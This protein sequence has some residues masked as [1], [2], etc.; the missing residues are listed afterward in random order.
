MSQPERHGD[1]SDSRDPA[2]DAP[3]CSHAHTQALSASVAVTGE[4]NR[5]YSRTAGCS[6]RGV[7][8]GYSGRAGGGGTPRAGF[9]K[10]EVSTMRRD[11]EH[12]QSH[13]DDDQRRRD[14][15]RQSDLCRPLPP[16]LVDALT[17]D[18]MPPEVLEKLKPEFIAPLV[19]YLASKENKETQMIFNCAAGW[20][21]R[22]AVCCAPGLCIGD[23]VRTITPEEI[24]ENWET[25]TSLDDAAPLKSVVDSFQFLTPLF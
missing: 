13:R 18:V 6:A 5:V 3:S 17:D 9:F 20:F 4:G 25:I 21:S 11:P 23:A 15:D 19:L 2:S 22:T 14:D 10:L 8:G 7:G 24:R 16:E 12:E 1:G